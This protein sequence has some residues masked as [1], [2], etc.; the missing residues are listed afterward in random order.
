MLQPPKNTS[1]HY[2][3]KEKKAIA[4]LRKVI[5]NNIPEG[6]SEVISYGMIGYVIPHEIYPE[7]YHCDPELPLPFLNI[8]SQKNHIAVYHAGIYADKKLLDWFTNEYSKHSTRKLDMGKSCIRF[9][10]ADQ[11]PLELIGELASKISTSE[12][13]SLYESNIKKK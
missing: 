8:A 4:A 11:I 10:K 5:L 2:Q 13:I 12:W 6:F 1:L 3:R 7:G 9:R